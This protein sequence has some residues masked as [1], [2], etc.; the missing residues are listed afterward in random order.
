VTPSQPVPRPPAAPVAPVGPHAGPVWPHAGP[1]WPHPA[2]VAPVGPHAGPVAPVGPHP[3]PAMWPPAPPPGFYAVRPVTAPPTFPVRPLRNWLWSI[4]TAL[5]VVATLLTVAGGAATAVA[6]RQA[7]ARVDAIFVDQALPDV[8]H[9]AL[10]ALLDRR[11]AAVRNKDKAAFMA[12]IDRADSAFV[13]R[14]EQE[15]ENLIR[16]P[17]SE[18]RYQ[19]E[20]LAQYDSLVPV[21][22]RER[23]HAVV[24]AAAVNVVYRIEGVDDRPVAAPWVPIFGLVGTSWRMVA[25][26]VD[27]S[28]PLGTNSQPWEAGPIGVARNG[29]VVAVLSADDMGRADA[30]LRMS[31]SALDQVAKVR[32]GSWAGRILVIAV[33]DSRLFDGYFADS[34]DRISQVA[35]VAVPNYSQVLSWNRSA[36]YAA[37]RIVFNPHEL[38]TDDAEMAHVLAHE[39]AHAAMGPV[40]T[41]NTPLW[42]VEGFAEYVAYAGRRPSDAFLHRVLADA[43]T[44]SLPTNSTFYSDSLNY[45][46]GWLACRMI[47][48]QFGEA[49]LVALYDAFNGPLSESAVLSQVLGVDE[50]TL[51]SRWASYVE[52]ARTA[53]LD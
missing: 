34:P 32:K 6:A 20:Q 30:L 12:D 4:L 53:T 11:S 28:L 24:R 40:T 29:R 15:Y 39:F 10:Q 17:F 42:L 16:L 7:N 14:Q 48:E 9:A 38:G 1:V 43:K 8:R 19:L 45:V 23:Y 25:T 13:K 31:E 22:L 46:L 21:G 27:T 18:F 3:G 33:Q 2:P 47:A 51:T 52:R 49:K 35:A 41:R 26:A 50:A 37:T 5:M 44:N 36:S